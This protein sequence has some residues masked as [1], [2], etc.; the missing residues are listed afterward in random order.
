MIKR[1]LERGKD[2]SGFSLQEL[3]IVALILGMLAAV[4][5]PSFVCQKQRAHDSAS[6]AITRAAAAAMEAY[7]N[8]NLG[9]YDGATA[10][11]LHGIEPTVPSSME[12]TPYANCSGDSGTTC[13]VVKSPPNPTSGNR[14]WL[15]KKTNGALLSDCSSHQIGGC[16]ADG[17]WSSE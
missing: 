15:T 16:P 9:A 12:V 6:K 2:E 8:D 4:G 10:T 3:I 5:L 11:I 14:F 13:Y 7:A 1:A 17:R